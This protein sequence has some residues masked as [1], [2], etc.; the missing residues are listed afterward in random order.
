MRRFRALLVTGA[1]V[2]G[3]TL[4]GATADAKNT[5]SCTF[6]RGETICTDVHGSHGTESGHHGQVNSNGSIT[7]EPTPC[8]VT[9]PEH[10]C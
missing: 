10:T 7:Q 1:V 8:K 2:C 6:S 9:G 5:S 4:G 3:F